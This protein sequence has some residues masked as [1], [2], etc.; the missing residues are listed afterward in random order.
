LSPSLWATC[1]TPAL[2]RGVGSA[3]IGSVV[4]A[5]LAATL[6][7][8]GPARAG[9][10]VGVADDAGKYDP[11]GGDWF[12]SELNNAGL[13]EN[14]VTVRW[15]ARTPEAISDKAFLDRSLQVASAHGIRV[16][17]SV[18]PQRA[19][20]IGNSAAARAQFADFLALLARTYPGVKDF[21]VGNEPN[22]PRFWRPQFDRRGAS[23]AGAAY[24]RVLAASYDALKAVDPGINVIGVALSP[25]GN[26]N[27]RAR[28]NVSRSPVRFLRDLGL[29]YRGSARALPLMDELAVHV[30]P[31]TPRDP[32]LK[33]YRWPNAGIPNLGRLKQAVWDAFHDTG[34]PTVE[35]GLTLKVAEAGWQ[36]RV[37]RSARQA[38]HGRENVRVTTEKQQASIYRQMIRFLVCD[39]DVT[40]LLF[41]GL[42]DQRDL[43]RF[44]A[45]LLRADRT[46]RASYRVVKSTIAGTGGRCVGRATHWR[47]STSV[48]GAGV[49]F[50]NLAR[51]RSERQRWWGFHVTADEEATYRAGIFTPESPALRGLA[52]VRGGS[53]P[54]GAILSATGRIKAS[55]RPV[56]RFPARRLARGAYVYAIQL[57]S[58]MNPERVRVFVSKPFT[59]GLP[60]WERGRATGRAAAP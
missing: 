40:S 17:F 35:E 5:F 54:N 31:Q 8:A 42:I 21:I 55:W 47:H 12:Y 25:R 19:R 23:L 3:T 13:T 32:L 16:I 1:D 10:A 38:Y 6:A 11:A 9:L 34:Q 57:R 15:D 48:V 22:Q 37:V 18:Y 2:V 29:A 20:A 46:R 59:V 45:G 58:A 24:E 53:F 39:S 27:P 4:A 14:R 51:P 52:R 26:D 41:F 56:V 60:E 50:G 44:Q 43:G 7:V 49:R 36:V 28:N 33:G 30:Y